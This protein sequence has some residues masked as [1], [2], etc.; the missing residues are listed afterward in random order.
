MSD[1]PLKLCVPIKVRPEGGLYT[2]V[3]NLLAWLERSGH[4]FT[5]DL[6]G[7][8]DVLFVNSWVVP[9]G[10]VRRYKRLRPDLRVVHRID[11]SAEDYGGDSASD[12]IQARVNL[13]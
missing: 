6:D 7:E 9:P 10:V 11:G 1:Q 12:A 4:Q 2:F 13:Y 5:Q 3:G 8:Y